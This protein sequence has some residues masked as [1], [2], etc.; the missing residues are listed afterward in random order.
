MAPATVATLS[1]NNATTMFLVNNN[2]NCRQMT[3]TGMYNGAKV[4]ALDPNGA[5][6]TT[7]PYIQNCTSVNTGTTGIMIDGNAQATGNKSMI[8]ND[9]TQINTDGK[10]V[11]V[12]NGVLDY[13]IMDF[14]SNWSTRS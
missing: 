14:Y 5:I 9:F 6:T 8:S 10:G 3:F 11:S 13:R 12:I 4:F 7:S 1:A 2:V